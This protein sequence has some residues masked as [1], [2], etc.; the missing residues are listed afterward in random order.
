MK[1]APAPY[2][3]GGAAPVPTVDADSIERSTPAVA[4]PAVAA[5]VMTAEEIAYAPEAVVSAEGSTRASDT[6]EPSTARQA[7]FDSNDEVAAVTP[8][9]TDGGTA[10]WLWWAA[11]GLLLAVAAGLVVLRRRL[12]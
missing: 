5:T 11:F 7:T 6:S 8:L 3:N 1:W 9:D 10:T 2:G 4:G 12:S